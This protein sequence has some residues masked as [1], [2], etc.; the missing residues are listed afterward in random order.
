MAESS[1]QSQQEPRKPSPSGVAG[2]VDAEIER[3]FAQAAQE[4]RGLQGRSPQEIEFLAGGRQSFEAWSLESHGWAPIVLKRSDAMEQLAER[5]AQLDQ[6]GDREHAARYLQ[7]AVARLK[8]R[9]PQQ[10]ALA[11]ELLALVPA[12]TLE[13][14]LVPPL[15]EL[16]DDKAVAF[17][18]AT[19]PVRQTFPRLAYRKAVQVGDV[20]RAAL[21][22]LTPFHFTPGT[23]FREW[24]QAHRNVRAHPWYWGK[25]WQ[26]ILPQSDLPELEAL[27]PKEGL[28]MLLLARNPDAVRAEAHTLTPPAA[29]A[30]LEY[31]ADGYYK[32]PGTLGAD[33][34]AA[35]VKKHR[36]KGQLL[37]IV[38]GEIPYPE[39][40]FQSAAFGLVQHAIS[41][42]KH[43]LTREDV[44]RLEQILAAP[45]GPLEKYPRYQTELAELATSL[46]PDRRAAILIAQLERN[47]GLHEVAVALLKESGLEH[48]ALIKKSYATLVSNNDDRYQL[49][50]IIREQ[51]G[52]E[53]RRR[54][55]ELFAVK[56]LSALE[57]AFDPRREALFLRYA[58]AANTISGAVII[59]EEEKRAA[60]YSRGKG[61]TPEA[62]AHNEKVPEHRLRALEKLEK[63]YHN[64]L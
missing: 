19:L 50:P 14:G 41:T 40:K 29:D 27:G 38:A 2:D 33:T 54:L 25:R 28:R 47:P 15:I 43:V 64:G 4:D 44:P 30:V 39:A 31:Q 45:R 8:H 49:I 22:T 57:P 58:D 12:T 16:L 21:A 63:F 42:L 23:G 13:L 3:V 10:R 7:A 6:K 24:W 20:A 46:A 5:V 17:S 62:A 32:I 59:T 48:W 51:A 52:N 61:S 36:L 53:A 18:G 9:Q 26:K 60:S 56:D 35:F 55:A 1:L 11:A 34:I 37:D